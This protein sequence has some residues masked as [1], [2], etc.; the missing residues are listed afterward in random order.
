MI[1]SQYHKK[2]HTKSIMYRYSL[3]QVIDTIITLFCIELEIKSNTRRPAY[4][5]LRGV[6]NGQRLESPA[7]GSLSP[8]SARPIVFLP[9]HAYTLT[10]AAGGTYQLTS[11]ALRS[12]TRKNYQCNQAAMT[13]GAINH[14]QGISR[15]ALPSL[16]APEP[17]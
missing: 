9:A 5:V 14:G 10:S 17:R 8:L 11:R 1:P 7:A 15:A 12:R 16:S 2:F 3:R 13:P 6:E 4:H